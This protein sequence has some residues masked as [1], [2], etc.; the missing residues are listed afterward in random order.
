MAIYDGC[1]GGFRLGRCFSATY[2]P[3]TQLRSLSQTAATWRERCHPAVTKGSD[4]HEEHR[5]EEGGLVAVGEFLG[6]SE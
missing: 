4:Q 5:E 1:H 6:N 2:A 3:D